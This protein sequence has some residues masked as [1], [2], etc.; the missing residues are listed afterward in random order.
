MSKIKLSYGFS[1][2][3]ILISIAIIGII[4]VIGTQSFQSVNS[5]EA[6]NKDSLQVI[7]VLRQARALTLDSK[8]ANQYGVHIQNSQV[9]MFEGAT[10]VNNATGN[11]TT[12]LNNRITI[13]QISLT[14]GGV[15]IVFD[16]LTGKT[17][18]DGTITLSLISDP[19]T[20]KIITIYKTGLAQIN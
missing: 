15:D 13:S 3:E 4:S 12:S 2:V 16:P 8:D 7:S 20:Q 11:I 14:G 5:S 9:I 17:G 19:A 18:E 10:Y 1:L 6:L